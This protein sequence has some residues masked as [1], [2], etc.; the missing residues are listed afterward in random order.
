M[1]EDEQELF[2]LISDP[3]NR[4]TVYDSISQFSLASRPNRKKALEALEQ[5][6]SKT[7]EL[8]TKYF[9]LLV[10]W[11]KELQEMLMECDRYRLVD[12]ERTRKIANPWGFAAAKT[13]PKSQ[14]IRKTPVEFEAAL[15]WSTVLQD[16]LMLLRQ[17]LA[18]FLATYQLRIISEITR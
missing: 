8:Q 17:H 13:V 4:E 3:F 14:L 1:L 5:Q 15:A 2:K 10:Y 12:L 18:D 16:L 7:V 9:L 6:I 11:G